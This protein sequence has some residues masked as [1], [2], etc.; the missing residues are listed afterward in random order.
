MVVHK[1]ET[2][3]EVGAWSRHAPEKKI[4]QCGLQQWKLPSTSVQKHGHLMP[5]L[6]KP[7]HVRRPWLLLCLQWI[8]GM[9]QWRLNA[10]IRGNWLTVTEVRAA[11]KVFVF[12]SCLCQASV[13]MDWWEQGSDWWS[14][15]ADRTLV[16]AVEF[17]WRAVSESI[18]C[19]MAAAFVMV[20]MMTHC[21]VGGPDLQDFPLTIIEAFFND[22]NFKGAWDTCFFVCMIS[23][24]FNE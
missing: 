9:W 7:L 17:G 18:N 10:C 16:L 14:A 12:I 11:C 22:Q 5:L 2:L 1:M 24:S 15:R 13:A 4:F 3:G 23:R 20:Y 6:L 19:E 21:I 8:W